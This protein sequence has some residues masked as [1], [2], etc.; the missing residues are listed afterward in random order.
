M[1]IPKH[2]LRRGAVLGALALLTAFV[3]FLIEEDL[4]TPVFGLLV[5]GVVGLGAWILL[6]PDELRDWL[7]GRQIYYGT[8][9]AILTVV[10]IGLAV[11]G[12]S[13]AEEQN[14]VR[15]LTDGQLYTIDKTSVR[16]LE[17][18]E[19]RLAFG[20][21]TA[22]IVGFYNREELRQRKSAEYLLQ[23][24]V[25]KS[26]GSLSLEFIDPDMEPLLARQYGY[27]PTSGL[28]PLYLTIFDPNGNRVTIEPIGGPEEVRIATAMLRISVAGQFKV[29][30]ITGHLEYN[31]QGEGGLGLSGVFRSLPL[32]GINTDILDITTARAIPDDATAIVI[33][34]AQLPYTQSDVDKIAAYMARGGRMLILAD[35]PYADPI[36]VVT[37]NTFLLEND[38]LNRYLWEEFGVRFREDLISDQASS[39]ENEF[40]LLPAR[41]GPSPIMDEQLQSLAVYFTLTRSIE[42]VDGSSTYLPNQAA[43]RRDVIFATSDSAFGETNL[44]DIDLDN[45]ANFVVG[46]DNP[47]PLAFAVSIRYVNELDADIQP[48]VVVMGDTDWLTNDFIAPSSG[49]DGIPGNI[50]LWNNTIEWLTRYS[51][52][53]SIPAASRPDLLPI[54]VTDRE[55]TRIQLITLVFLPG[56][57]LGVGVLVWGF[58]RQT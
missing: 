5:V 42:L 18:M 40:V 4:S 21:F 45:R 15:D 32:A 47:G 24:Y 33:A 43:Y 44:R 41:I 9:S 34:G 14:L 51:E 11:A 20:G 27:S 22:R 13:L 48:R 26:D 23:Q 31:A 16:A 39:I 54:T 58:R 56:V 36:S 29:Y 10:V 19:S 38:P 35:P 7:T 30:F 3:I 55:Q 17:Q 52:I 49:L 6:A 25:E 57:I 12:Y 2:W 37:P 28:G 53:A 46:E 50:K 1:R 8:G